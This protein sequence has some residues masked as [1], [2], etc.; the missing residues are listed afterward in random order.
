MTKVLCNYCQYVWETKSKL[1]NVSC[2]SCL[3]KVEVCRNVVK[4]EANAIQNGNETKD[5]E[6]VK[7]SA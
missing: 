3:K 6:N 4:E 5:K 7:R 1:N 2:P